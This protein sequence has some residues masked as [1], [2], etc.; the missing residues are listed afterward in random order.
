M[1][2]WPRNVDITDPA[3]RQYPG[4]PITV[5]Q[6]NNYGRTPAAY[7]PTLVI[8]G[9]TGPVVQI[10]DESNNEIVYTLRIKGDRFRP[11][12]FKEGIY[13]IKVGEDGAQ[14]TLE[15]IASLAPDQSGEI[16]VGL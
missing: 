14:A 4:W 8:E 5:G 11:K 7:L 6:E 2:C 1:E 9:R 10:V 3:A 13:T 12:V 16:E 15:G